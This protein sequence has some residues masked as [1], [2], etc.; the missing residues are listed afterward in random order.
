MSLDGQL[1]LA[2]PR[3]RDPNF[4]RAV[5]LILNHDDDGALG[6]VL[7][8]PSQ[9][10]VAEVLPPWSTV[11]AEPQLVFGGGPVGQDSA[12]AVGVALGEG[13]ASGFHRVT[14]SYGLVDLDAQPSDVATD[15]V[16]LRVFAGYAG[17]GSGQLEGEI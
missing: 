6:V 9:L 3:L 2:T 1:L 17:W 4:V 13:P 5:I 14:S 12:L 7:N 15:L 16:G 8:R 11:V 10:A